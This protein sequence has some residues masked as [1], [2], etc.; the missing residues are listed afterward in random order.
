[1]AYAGKWGG[2]SKKIEG[3]DEHNRW[4]KPHEWAQ[5]GTDWVEN[6]MGQLKG[7]QRPFEINWEISD[8]DIEAGA[9][10]TLSIRMHG[11]Q[12]SGEHGGISVSFPSLTQSGGSTSSYSSSLAD[13]EVVGLHDG[14]IERNVPSTGCN[15]L[16]PRRESTVPCRV[17]ARRI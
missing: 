11:L 8:Y 1:M 3:P 4:H 5:I 12:E 2:S 10:F 15:H 9:S 6:K 13:V 17:P 16:S 7:D 14:H